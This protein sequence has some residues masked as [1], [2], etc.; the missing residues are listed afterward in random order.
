[1]L[2]VRAP[3]FMA[4]FYP[5]RTSNFYNDYCFVFV[6]CRLICLI[7]GLIC[8]QWKK[9]RKYKMGRK[10]ANTKLSSNKTV[11]SVVVGKIQ[12]FEPQ[13]NERWFLAISRRDLRS[14]KSCR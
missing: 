11:R 12:Q 1:M 2:G 10:A 6:H 7:M 8:S 14:K 13:A 3:I 4:P 5:G 9:K